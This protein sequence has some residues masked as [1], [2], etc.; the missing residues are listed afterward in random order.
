MY[1]T[2][3]TIY[4]TQLELLKALNKPFSAIE[5]STL[6]EKFNIQANATIPA[7]VYPELKYM[8][9]GRGGHRG[10]LTSSGA[11][12]VDV[13]QHNIKHAALYEHIPF[14]VREVD[15]DLSVADRTK[16]GMRTLIERNGVHYFAYYLKKIT[17][18]STYPVIEELTVAGGSVDSITYVPTP[19]QLS[20]APIPYSNANVNVSTG[21]HISVE[22]AVEVVFTKDD[23]AEIIAGVEILYGDPG[24]ATISEMATVTAIPTAVDTTL[25]GVNISYEEALVAQIANHI[26]ANLDIR[27]TTE[28]IKQ[29]I[30]IGNTAPYIV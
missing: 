18:D 30:F 13:I 6:N 12:L 4:N 11:T 21:K 28:S 1:A 3:K 25:G 17:F 27:Y 15:N 29:T 7:G 26:P 8:A 22:S 20:P 23:L 10:R 16:Y 9:I 19:S 24:F 5:Y 14:I 2:I